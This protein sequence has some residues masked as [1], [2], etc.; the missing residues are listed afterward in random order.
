M[1]QGTIF[2]PLCRGEP[3]ELLLS[4]FSVLDFVDFPAV[5]VLL[6]GVLRRMGDTEKLAWKIISSYR[7]YDM[8]LIQSAKRDQNSITENIYD[9][10]SLFQ[11]A[12]KAY[13]YHAEFSQIESNQM[14]TT[15]L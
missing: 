11:K 3:L 5:A 12:H 4:I 8:C 7:T 13:I 14:P 10:S 6:Q 2:V 1:I 9:L 15:S